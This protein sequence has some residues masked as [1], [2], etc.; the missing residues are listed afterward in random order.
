MGIK[1]KKAMARLDAR[2]RDF[3]KGTQSREAK[4]QNRWDAK[5]YHRPGS[6]NK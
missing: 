1:R 6:N 2:R 4:V 3:D 5:G